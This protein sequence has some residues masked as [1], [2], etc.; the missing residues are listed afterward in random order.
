[1]AE[2]VFEIWRDDAAGEQSMSQVSEQADRVRLATMPNATLVYSFTARSDFDAFQRNYDWNGWGAWK[3]E[4][5]WTEQ[6][7]TDAEAAD[8][9]RYLASRD[10]R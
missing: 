6:P 3:P 7:F 9:A 8:Q 4:P 2:L 5:Y 10:V 1:M